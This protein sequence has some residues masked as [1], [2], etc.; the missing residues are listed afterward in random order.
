MK[1]KAPV[2]QNTR[3]L[4]LQL[5]LWLLVSSLYGQL[6]KIDSF[7][8]SQNGWTASS[9]AYFL[10]NEWNLKLGRDLKVKAYM[11]IELQKTMSR[12]M[13]EFNK[14]VPSMALIHLID[15]GMW[16]AGLVEAPYRIHGNIKSLTV[17]FT[18]KNLIHQGQGLACSI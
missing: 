5:S 14:S 17:R 16:C 10:P 7:H 18:D 1:Q 11:T 12:S 8:T 15:T 13:K 4:G 9:S 3:L 2:N 6:R